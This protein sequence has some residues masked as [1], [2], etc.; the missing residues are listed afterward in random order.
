ML[1]KI[2]FFHCSNSV[3]KVKTKQKL[4]SM[5]VFRRMSILCL[6]NSLHK[7]RFSCSSAFSCQSEGHIREVHRRRG[8]PHKILIRSPHIREHVESWTLLLYGEYRW[9]ITGLT[10]SLTFADT[11]YRRRGV[12]KKDYKFT[13]FLGGKTSSLIK[14]ELSRMH[15]SQFISVSIS[16]GSCALPQPCDYIDRDIAGSS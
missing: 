8:A 13:F 6:L 2:N 5:M 16:G 10:P 7:R 3:A 11:P 1:F 12:S 9:K 15:L 4:P 14:T